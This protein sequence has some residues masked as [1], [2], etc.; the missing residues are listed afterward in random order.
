M[1]TIGIIVPVRNMSGQLQNLE[2]WM[3][4]C[5]NYSNLNIYIVHDCGDFKTWS[6]LREMVDKLDNK[7]IILSE[8]YAG[9]PGGARNFGL[10]QSNDDYITFWDSDDIGYVDNL[11]EVVDSSNNSEVLICNYEIFQDGNSAPIPQ[12]HQHRFSEIIKNPGI[13]RF[14][15][16]RKF[17]KDVRFEHLAMGED[18]LFL[19]QLNI[20]NSRYKFSETTTYCYVVNRPGSLTS[21]K[22]VTDL[23]KVVEKGSDLFFTQ[24]GESLMF[25]R[26]LIKRQC[27][28]LIRYGTIDLK[29][30][31]ISK[32]CTTLLVRV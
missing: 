30:F 19:E 27:L 23:R 13:W 4:N 3:S 15:F 29:F 7:N 16:E 22:K 24:D 1:K 5:G 14:V 10:N 31:G 8:C 32:L 28:T 21:L 20:P 17:I 11:I 25:T 12:E 26:N 18:Q 9:N 6:E 2:S